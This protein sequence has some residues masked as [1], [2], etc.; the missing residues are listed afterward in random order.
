MQSLIERIVSFANA[1]IA[2]LGDVMLDRFVYGH[3]AR[4]SPE[5]PVPVMRL[6]HGV[7][8]LGGAGNLACN[9]TRMGGQATLISTVG[10][11]TAGDEVV[12]VA[13]RERGLVTALLREPQRITTVK[14]RFVSQGQQLLRVDEESRHEVDG[15]ATDRLLASLDVALQDAKVLVCSDYAKGVLT[16]TVLER[17]IRHARGQGSLVIVDP[18]ARD[19]RRYRG[20]TVITPN[21]HEATNA[22]GIDCENDDGVERAARKIADL[23]DC[24]TVVVTRGPKGMSVLSRT[25]SGEEIAHFPTAAREVH[26]VSGAGDTVIAALSLGL[27]VD[28]PINDAAKLANIAAGIAVAKVGTSPVEAS[29]LA[30]AIQVSEFF[31]RKVKVVSLETAVSLAQSWRRRGERIVFTNGCF[32]LLHPGHVRL[33]ES[34]KAHGD[35][36]IVAI[37]SDA[38]VNRLKGPGRPVQNENAR[39]IVM[40]SI[41]VVDLVTV[42]SAD[43]PLEVIEA[44][45]PD[46]LVKGSDYSEDQIVGADLVKARGGRVVLVELEEGHST[47]A[48]VRRASQGVTQL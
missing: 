38:S 15:L 41:G 39:A 4:I 1:R 19:F 26:D 23:V 42:F 25:G 34:A 14:T 31:E 40:S 6:S 28:M 29:E 43:T 44:V 3:V 32:D 30:H 11:D 33:L 8:M 47:S 10:A 12:A 37:N 20:A 7:S 22:S 9:V 21:V 48:T 5:A 2:V 36:L 45:Q 17:A 46:V 18:K 13:N 24:R 35:R 16:E 27:A